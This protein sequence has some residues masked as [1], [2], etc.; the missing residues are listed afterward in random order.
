MRERT[1]LLLLLACF[2]LSGLA[3]LIYQTAWTRQFAFVFGTSELA[4]ATVLAAYMAGLAI[5]AAVGARLA[6][7]V[8]RPVLAYG[9]LELG[10]GLSAVAVPG[11]IA[12][13][14]GLYVRL[15]SA[16]GMAEAAGTGF[17]AFYLACSLLILVVPTAFMGATLPLLIRH[18]VRR[19]DE[20][21]ARVSI[22][23]GANTVGAVAGTVL[24]GFALLP[25]F[26]LRTTVWVAVA[27]NGLVFLAAVALAR[28]A[29]AP[30]PAPVA[31]ER[32]AVG[33]RAWILPAMLLSG[34]ASFGYE[35]LWTRLLGHV[36]GGSV[37][38]FATMLATF[39]TGIAL[40]ALAAG[41]FASSPRRAAA[42]F[43]WTQ[44]GTA[45]CS[46][47]AYLSLAA[48]PGLV[49][50]L[51]A[52][53][54][55]SAVPDAIVTG[56]V[57]LPSTLCIGATFPLAVRVLAERE[58]DAGPASARVYAWNT[59]GAIVGAIGAGFFVI[60][61]LGY[62]PSLTAAIVLNLALAAGSVLL[63]PDASRRV[64]AVA[65]ALL[66]ALMFLRIQP[67]WGILLSSLGAAT[68]QTGPVVSY[69][70][71]RSATVLTVEQPH[72]FQLR[73]NGLTEAEIL[74]RGERAAV[75]KASHWL[76][77]LPVL[78]RPDAKSLFSI[79]LG[80]GVA[81]E[82]LPSTLDRIDVVEL[83]P[84][85]VDANRGVGS[86]RRSDPL[87]DPRV[88]VAENDARAT[89]L[90]T[91]QRYDA[92]ISQ[93]SHP[94]SAGA[95]HLYTQDFFELVRSRLAE[96]GVF[97]QWI[98]SQFIDVE[99]LGTLVATLRAVFP[100][101][102]VYSPIPPWA[103]LFLAS[104]Q[105]LD[106]EATAARAIAGSPASFI[107]VALQ[108]ETDVRIG[109]MMSDEG[110][111]RF[112]EG[113]PV[114]T[115]DHNLLQVRSPRVLPNYVENQKALLEALG[116]H[117][118]LLRQ[119]DLD[120][121][122]YVIRR[123]VRE[124]QIDRALRVAGFQA[125][126]DAHAALHVLIRALVGQLSSDGLATALAS[127]PG[128]RE[129]RA[130]ALLHGQEEL[131][132]P[133]SAEERAVGAARRE[134]AANRWGAVAAAD[135][136]LA[137]LDLRHPLS[138]TAIRLRAGW[139]VATGDAARAREAIVLLEVVLSVWPE[140]SD[141]VLRAE[142]GRLAGEPDVALASAR[143]LVGRPD[144]STTELSELARILSALS[145]E[146]GDRARHDGLLGA[147]KARGEG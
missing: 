65:G 89:L 7:R 90:L 6:P 134:A 50:A 25:A 94:W 106:V 74:R 48:V 111:R 126:A 77:L 142:A 80:G 49:R 47:G 2:F 40:G 108:S 145:V 4:V 78:A 11:A 96:D 8:K 61:A 117:D 81:I 19:E 54:G 41:R 68:Q 85:V 144:A 10:V 110:S 37:Y 39:L 147:L 55:A 44:L 63:F 107:G 70:V 18:A 146:E 131:T 86:Q 23:Y 84:R 62:A 124:R 57:L 133:L 67:P 33:R 60:P 9:V 82:D 66:V 36:L 132:P 135:A 79:G 29:A 125:D 118:P 73:T 98:G 51:A 30:P 102:E 137:S 3:A 17:T 129:L 138:E 116:R 140:T 130:L 122:G 101:V 92:I 93:P 5:G 38:A 27:V 114:N 24:A 21:G 52:G 91:N 32:P 87:A 43:G 22:L 58:S 1:S 46:V 31:S 45:L 104:E 28:T 120:E 113:A 26:G 105:P 71:G 88:H 76:G 99:L 115:D 95:A 119:L 14:R 136:V 13:S 42:A 56:L 109:R 83:E 20:I 34:I 127:H 35:V 69:A 139:R 143:E 75:D 97:V 64:L 15:F 112:A 12:L 121:A 141:L 128:N 123:L 16:A 100:H 103:I 72:G 53:T 59:V